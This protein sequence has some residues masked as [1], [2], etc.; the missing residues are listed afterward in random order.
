MCKLLCHEWLSHNI[1]QEEESKMSGDR[2]G[3]RSGR[4]PGRRPAKVDVKAKLER[5]RQSARECRARKKLR[6]Q[7]LEDL[8]SSREQAIFRLRDELEL[9]KQWCIQL[10]AGE[11]PE[12]IV[13]ML[14]KGTKKRDKNQDESS[15]EDRDSPPGSS[16]SSAYSH[17]SPDNSQGSPPGATGFGDI[18]YPNP[19]MRDVN[20][21]QTGHG[22]MIPTLDD[23]G[24]DQLFSPWRKQSPVLSTQRNQNIGNVISSAAHTASFTGQRPMGPSFTS[25]RPISTLQQGL[26]KFNAIS[27][28]GHSSA[29]VLDNS[30]RATAG[31]LSRRHSDYG[32]FRVVRPEN[33]GQI[34]V[35]SQI[36]PPLSSPMTSAGPSTFTSQ[37]GKDFVYEY[38]QR[39]RSLEY[40]VLQRPMTQ[41][42]DSVEMSVGSDFRTMF[43]G[44]ELLNTIPENRGT[45]SPCQIVPKFDSPHIPQTNIATH[46]WNT[47]SRGIQDTIES[48]LN[49]G[50][51]PNEQYPVVLTSVEPKV[52]NTYLPVTSSNLAMVNFSTSDTCQGRDIKRD[53]SSDSSDV[54]NDSILPTVLEDFN[55]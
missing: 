10:D 33:P 54:P 47:D 25:Q 40:T 6:Y 29:N 53:H 44:D 9:C 16:T 30:G 5:S 26:P 7:Y 1:T 37:T 35:S 55:F 4:R 13:E 45:D 34:P 8:V 18:K 17:G 49:V 50:N 36:K 24:G 52:S 23:T 27:T 12:N 43:L 28:L 42:K 11:I 39:K 22:S 46:A 38:N 48:I 3:R 51:K 15:S 20:T 21:Y 31:S 19:I 2:S 41:R 32:A 14:A